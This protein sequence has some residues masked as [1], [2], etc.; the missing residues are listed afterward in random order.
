MISLWSFD[1]RNETESRLGTLRQVNGSEYFSTHAHAG[2]PF[3][4]DEARAL[5]EIEVI[6]GQHEF[7]LIDIYCRNGHPSYPVIQ[8]QAFF[9]RHKHGDTQFNPP[10]FAAVYLLA[11]PWWEHD[12]H[13][14]QHPK[15][16]VARL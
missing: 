6:V 2:I 15:P 10:L 14:S 8:E 16:D 5:S 11:L 7:V 4:D 3:P 12:P 13:L 1:I 9:D